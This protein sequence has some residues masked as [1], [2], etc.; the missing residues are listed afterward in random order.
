[1]RKM[2][3]AMRAA[4]LVVFPG[5]FGTLDELF[6]IMTLVQTG[7]MG[8]VPIVL[9]DS[10]YWRGLLNLET[11]AEAGFIRPE[12]L[13]LFAYADTPEETYQRIVD[14]AGNGW[15]APGNGSVQS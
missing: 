10:G 6:E 13:K 9:Y 5:G 1:M 3:L 4:A 14:G 15:H 11:M 7:K 2:H 8:P 12:D